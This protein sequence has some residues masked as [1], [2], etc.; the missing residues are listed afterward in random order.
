MCVVGHVVE[1][2]AGGQESPYGSGI[3]CAAVC[4]VG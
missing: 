2:V 4:A 1:Y 3:A